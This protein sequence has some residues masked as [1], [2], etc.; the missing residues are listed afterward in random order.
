MLN[1]NSISEVNKRLTELWTDS[2]EE[3]YGESGAK[4]REGEL[5]VL[6]AV[7]SWGW[8]VKDNESDF[9]QQVA[10]QDIWIKKP[11]WKN[12]Y[13]IDVKANLDKYGS[14]YVYPD[15][16][17]N[18]KKKNH[19]FWHVNVETGWMAWYDRVQMQT[20]LKTLTSNERIRIGIRD[21]IPVDIT[22]ARYGK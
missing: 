14:F 21:N 11:T 6:E 12:F 16:W 13:S 15:Q 3:A 18:P 10:G 2:L 19:R 8:E 7:R 9:N 5:F 17:L 4:G 1:Y 22:R 20:Y